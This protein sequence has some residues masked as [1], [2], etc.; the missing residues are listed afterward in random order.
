MNLKNPI[1]KFKN[2]LDA[3]KRVNELEAELYIRN[4]TCEE[5]GLVI[6]KLKEDI[7]TLKNEM[8]SLKTKSEYT[9]NCNKDL[10]GKVK[11]LKQKIRIEEFDKEFSEK[12]LDYLNYLICRCM[13]ID[14]YTNVAVFQ[15]KFERGRNWRHPIVTE[16]S[17]LEQFQ[18]NYLFE[19][20]DHAEILRKFIEGLYAEE[21]EKFQKNVEKEISNCCEVPEIQEEN[22]EKI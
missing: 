4:K 20:N 3:E 5:R 14:F 9:S 12:R 8:K 7:K 15:S 21:L 2:L 16:Y 22:V 18:K 1:K 11:E 19:M 10:R 17:N 6:D 13:D